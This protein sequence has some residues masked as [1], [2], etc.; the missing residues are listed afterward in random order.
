MTK[1][2]T[3][4]AH[5]DAGKDVEQRPAGRPVPVPQLL[6][7]RPSIHHYIDLGSLIHFAGDVP[8]VL[9]TAK[10]ATGGDPLNVCIKDTAVRIRS[11]YLIRVSVC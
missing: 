7:Y 8:A 11:I 10:H 3:L 9:I 1:T 2:Q 6:R 4:S 5:R